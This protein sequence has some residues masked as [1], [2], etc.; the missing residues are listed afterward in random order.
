[1][2]YWIKTD[3]SVEEVRYKGNKGSIPLEELQRMV[4]G[5]IEIVRFRNRPDLFF[6]AANKTVRITDSTLMVVDEEGRLKNKPLNPVGCV[7]YGT[8]EHGEPI[9][10]DIVLAEYP[11]EVD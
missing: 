6:E 8:Q 1:M 4:G 10:G 3:G 5:N 11:R 2:A 9:V 7:L